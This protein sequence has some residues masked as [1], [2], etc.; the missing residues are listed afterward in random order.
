MTNNLRKLIYLLSDGDV[1]SGAVLG[2]KLGVT[3]A[4]VWKLVKQLEALDIPI[5]KKTNRGYQI[6]GGLELLNIE[7]IMNALP[8]DIATIADIIIEQ[9]VSSTNDYLL[10][11]QLPNSK[12][13]SVCIAEK[14]TAGRGRL[15]RKWYS[16]YGQCLILSLRWCFPGNSNELSG[17]SLAMALAVVHTLK[18]L[19]QMPENLRLKWPNDIFCT[20]K[21]GG[22]LIDMQGEM[23][24]NTTIVIGIGLNIS[25]PSIASEII[26]TTWTDLESVLNE[27]PSRNKLAAKLI[28]EIIKVLK[29]FEKEGL[30]PFKE[31]WM[32]YDISFGHPVSIQTNNTTIKGIGRSIDSK[33][34]FL[35]EESS[36]GKIVSYGSG[37]VS[38]LLNEGVLLNSEDVSK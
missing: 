37:D 1:H 18:D 12:Q 25:M 34:N 17:L 14:Q 9:T 21:L 20:K 5:T 30:R 11:H 10:R 7:K 6:P 4:G 27:K 13:F 22:I 24:G 29:T 16:P 35:I 32:T 38:L 3:R 26:K 19:G 36:S 28:E 2:Q 8:V 23:N 31:A 33:G 15:G